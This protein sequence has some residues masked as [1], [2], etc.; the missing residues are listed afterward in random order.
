[1][2]LQEREKEYE[3]LMEA[4]ASA[5]YRLIEQSKTEP[6]DPN[7][8]DISKQLLLHNYRKYLLLLDTIDADNRHIP[9]Q[10]T[11]HLACVAVKCNMTEINAIRE[12]INDYGRN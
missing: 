10:L 1:M 9:Q 12:V 3:C 4:Y 8:P 5:L 7:T 2:T 11:W 6:I